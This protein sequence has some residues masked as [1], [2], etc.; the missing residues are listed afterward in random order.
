MKG[1]MANLC[2][3]I[4]VVNKAKYNNCHYKE[5]LEMNK[6]QH[7]VVNVIAREQIRAITHVDVNGEKHLLG[8]HRDFRRN[9]N[10]A[11]FIPESGRL[12]FAWVRLTDGETLDVHQHPTKSMIIVCSGSV[13][14][15]GDE[16]RQLYEGDIV[17][18]EPFRNHGFTT[19][20]GETFHGLSIQFEGKGLYEDERQARVTFSDALNNL[21]QVNETLVGRHQNNALFQL[22]SSGR[23]QKDAQLRQR[24]V[25]ALYV[26]SRYFQKMVLAR[27]ALC[28]TPALQEEYQRHFMEEVGH[29]ELLRV[30]Y[31]INDEVYDP[32][33][34]AA[35]NW[36]VS[37]MYQQDEAG[38]VVVVHLVVES[39]GHVFGLATSEIFHKPEVE[40]DY[41][42]VHAEADDDHRSIGQAYLHSLPA[43]KNTIATTVVQSGLGHDGFGT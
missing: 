19:R 42:D 24:F 32:I 36:F 17:C 10:L 23:L 37:Q 20:E 8:Q 7:A 12:S 14:L 29:D 3:F 30:R 28:I 39:S 18:V 5:S 34:E 1:R 21:Y 26:W 41:F 4:V 13:Q 33:L 38:K 43:E 35:G 16:P 22:F 31:E 15:T 11:H 25:S 2:D 6:E 40:G 27:Q 9:E